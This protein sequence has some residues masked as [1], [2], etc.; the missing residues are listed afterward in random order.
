[1][2]PKNDPASVVADPQWLPFHYDWQRPALGFA[3]IERARHAELTFLAEE[4]VKELAPPVRTLS[5]AEV[6]GAAA[7]LSGAP[8]YVFHSAFCCSTLLARALDA[9]GISMALNEPQIVNHL[10]S[11]AL[12]KRLTGDVLGLVVRL[13]GRPFGAGE[14]VVVKPSNEANLLA[15]PLLQADPRSKAIFLYAP[16]PRFLRSV[17]RKGMWGRIWAR[18][19]LQTMRVHT[20]LEF[21]LG[22][23]ELFELTDL[24][25]AAL[26][27][28]SHHAQGAALLAAFPDRVRTLDSAAFLANR[29]QTL[30][31]L[32][33]HFGLNLDE[34]AARRIAEGPAFKTHSKEIGRSFDGD[35]EPDNAAMPIVDEEIEMVS[36]WT[37]AIAQQMDLSIEMSAQ[38]MLV[39]DR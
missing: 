26:A 23:R 38:S 36:T 24:Q 15:Q 21:G 33:K 37:R 9:P 32:G 22:E 14:A 12:Q 10:A 25:A 35:A 34:A 11:A 31:A 3:S 16:L 8:H 18:R 20:G 2:S 17:A 4:Y 29:A 7:S 5:I 19:L 28:L 30:S 27:W 39:P 13:L 6:Q 1:M